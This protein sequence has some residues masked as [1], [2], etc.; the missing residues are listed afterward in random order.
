MKKEY[1]NTEEEVVD[2]LNRNHLTIATA[3]SC[4]GG[5]V[6]ATLINVSGVSKALKESYITYADETK[7]KILHV[8]KE[9]LEKHTAVS[10]ETAR[11][12][13]CGVTDVAGTDVGISVTGIAGPDGGSKDFPVGLVYIGWKVNNAVSVQRFVF[14]GDRM[15]VRHS[16]VDT[17]LKI[18]IER[19]HKEGYR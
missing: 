3:E 1:V 6:A 12:M 9:T 13:V 16:A 11:E 14:A 2:I 18:L 5:L 10:E 4:T 15:Q 8:S 17:A 7:Q 19:L